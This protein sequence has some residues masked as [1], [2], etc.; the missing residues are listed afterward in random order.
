MKKFVF[1][2]LFLLALNLFSQYIPGEKVRAEDNLSWTDS[3]GYS[4]N[5]FDEIFLQKNVV[6]LFWGGFG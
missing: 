1:A 4:T 3:D 5:I 6:V 2:S